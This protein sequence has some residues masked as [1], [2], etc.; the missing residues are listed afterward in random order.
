MTTE[1][2]AEK[3]VAAVSVTEGAEFAAPAPESAEDAAE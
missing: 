2:M 1:N 3:N